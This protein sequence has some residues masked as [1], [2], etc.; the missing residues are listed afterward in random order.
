MIRPSRPNSFVTQDTGGATQ[1]TYALQLNPAPLTV[2]VD[3][4]DPVFGS[5]EFVITNGTAS[6]ISVSEVDFTIQVG[7]DSSNLTPTTANVGTSVSDTTNWEIQSPGTV[8]SE[9]ATFTLTPVTGSSV[10]LAAGHSVLVLI[11]G[12]QT[13]SDSGNTTIKVKEI[14]GTVAYTNFLVTT[15]PAGF[16]FNGLSATVLNGSQLTPVAQV[17]SGKTVTLVWN[18]SVMDVTSFTIYY[19]TSQGPQSA[20]PTDTGEWTSLPLASDTVFTVVVTASIGGGGTLS[21]A[22]STAVSVQNP[23]LIAETASVTG[24]LTAMGGAVI[25]GGLTSDT[26]LVTGTLT[27]KGGAAITGG[28]TSDTARIDGPSNETTNPSLSLGGNGNFN[29]DAPGVVGGRLVVQ[30]TTGY[31]GINTPSPTAQLHVTG[32]M[33]VNG[34]VTV[35]GVLTG[36]STIGGGAAQLQGYGVNSNAVFALKYDDQLY[37][38]GNPDAI[39]IMN[40]ID[41]V[42]K[43]FIINHPVFAEKYLMHATLEGPEAA[44]FYRGSTRLENGRAEIELPHYFDALCDASSATIQLT[45]VD[46]FDRLCLR[47]YDGRKI[48]RDRFLVVSDNPTSDLA[49]D[50][51]VKARR[52]DVPAIVVEPRKDDIIVRGDGPYRYAMP[53]PKPKAA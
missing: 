50:W 10:T 35:N 19:S 23:S 20:T 3:G 33:I 1:L 4:R 17:T 34:Q 46:G 43:T 36:N 29:I 15:F 13:V 37:P 12:F 21:A 41:G 18:S 32:S 49:F 48:H 39:Q 26:A 40:E 52:K 30:D 5:L 38:G 31:V 6:P 53:R 25:T 9:S 45:P 24:T 16:F 22:L 27:A 47:T 8:T 51:E 11:D 42:Y 7:T 44:V 14:T 28:L 2:S